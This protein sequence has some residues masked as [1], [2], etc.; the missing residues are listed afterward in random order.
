VTARI[1][2]SLRNEQGFY[3]T[4]RINKLKN[5][6]VTAR[7]SV[8][9]RNEQRFLVHATNKLKNAKVKAKMPVSLRNEQGF[10]F[11]Q[12]ISFKTPILA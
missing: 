2:I 6:E 7:M 9:L 10:Y 12:R 8:S 4:Y 11:R 1:S 5:A 3:F